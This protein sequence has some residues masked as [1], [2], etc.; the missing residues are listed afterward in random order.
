GDHVAT[1]ACTRQCVMERDAILAARVPL[2]RAALAWVGHVQTRNCGTVGGSLAHADPAAE[3][4]LAACILSADLLLRTDNTSRIVNARDFFVGP[5]TT[6]L[7]AHECLE[8]IRWPVWH[9]PALGCAFTEVSRRHGDFA[10]VAAGAQIALDESGCCTH[11]T[12]GLAGGAAVPMAFPALADRLVGSRGGE[13]LFTEIA[14]DA[15][16]ALDPGGDLHA[17]PDYRRHL[18]AALA[19]RVLRAAWMQAEQPA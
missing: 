10:L 15:A 1:G 17:S 9:E 5:L 13:E 7:E 12:F 2:L 19:A 16:R 8:E 18:A 14:Q 11:A 4:P 6:A 3:L